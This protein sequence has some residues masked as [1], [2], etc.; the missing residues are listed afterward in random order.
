MIG[1]LTIV[2][3]IPK[4]HFRFRINNDY[5]A[6]INGI[7]KDYDSKN[8]IITG[9]FYKLDTPVFHLINRSEYGKGTDFKKDVLEVNGSNC[10][11]PSGQYCFIKCINYL[12]GE[13]YETIRIYKKK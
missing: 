10:Y 12:T 8:S 4:T 3:H 5:E 2:E 1:D 11:V 9:V 6:Y 7:D 13:N